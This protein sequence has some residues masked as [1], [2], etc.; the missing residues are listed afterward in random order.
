MDI[1]KQF[2]PGVYAMTWRTEY[3]RETDVA[4]EL[5]RKLCDL[6]KQRQV[7]IERLQEQLQRR[8]RQVQKLSSSF[9]GLC[10]SAS[11]SSFDGLTR[12]LNKSLTDFSELSE[13]ST[14]I[15]KHISSI[16]SIQEEMI[17]TQAGLKKA[18]GRRDAAFPEFRMRWMAQHCGPA[19]APHSFGV[20]EKSTDASKGNRGLAPLSKHTTAVDPSSA[21]GDAVLRH[22]SD[23]GKRF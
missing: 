17:A 1:T 23:L 22:R 10:K 16:S 9:D 18:L 8:Q 20:A 4:V 19:P 5:S 7:T 2:G 14:T 6:E 13:L 11:S 3:E 12:D 21:V 15:S